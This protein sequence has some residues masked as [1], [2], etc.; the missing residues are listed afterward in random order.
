M[1]A[2]TF[3][4]HTAIRYNECIAR[5]LQGLT[6][7]ISCKAGYTYRVGCKGEPPR[8]DNN[9]HAVRSEATN[10]IDPLC[11][12]RVLHRSCFAMMSIACVAVLCGLAAEALLLS[13]PLS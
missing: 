11:I 2:L 6:G 8:G 10:F 12:A 3:A 1:E 9:L 7:R 4:T 5:V 13:G